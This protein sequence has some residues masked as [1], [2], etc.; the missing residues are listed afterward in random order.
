[1]DDGP[2]RNVPWLER[3]RL[4]VRLAA[5][6][7]GRK[8]VK[9]VIRTADAWLVQGYRDAARSLYAKALEL[10]QEFKVY[11]LEKVASKRLAEFEETHKM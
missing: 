3:L 10:A 1:M 8:K 5:P 11:H 4:K 9:A 2:S 7:D 6:L